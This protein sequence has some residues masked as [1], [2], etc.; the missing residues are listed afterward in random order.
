MTLQA[1]GLVDFPLALGYGGAGGASLSNGVV[2]FD[3]ATDRLAWVGFSYI[4]DA[5]HKIYF[6]TGTVTT[7]DTVEVRIETVTNGKPSGTLWAA[8]TNVTVA[9]A[10]SDDNVWKTAALTADASVVIGSLYAIV[11]IH[12]SGATPNEQ[13]SVAAPWILN[14]Q[15]QVP[16]IWQDT[17]GGTW[18]SIQGAGTLAGYNWIVEMTTAG[19]VQTNGL[20][21]VDTGVTNT[22][23]S[24][25]APNEKALRF[26]VPFKCRVIGAK[27]SMFN[28]AAAADFTVTLWPASSTTD[29]D[30][31]AQK[32]V[33]GDTTVSTTIDGNYLVYLSAAVTL[34]VNTTYYLGLRADTANNI[35]LGELTTAGT[36]EPATAMNAF[37]IPNAGAI[38]KSARTWTAGTAGAWTN[39]TTTMPLISLIL[40]QLDDGAGGSAGML[41]TPNLEGI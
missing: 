40:D 35:T 18:T 36:G 11:I 38:Y 19:V 31:L 10:D 4:A 34:S 7:G 27:V 1:C 17:G 21:P 8:N 32:A 26:Q 30:A 29:A 3:S 9:I 15:G 25:S 22:Y 6:R 2:T 28:T 41:Y 5:I 23:N 20:F 14:N 39:T 12:S 33:D 16:I 24:G 13:F 37:P